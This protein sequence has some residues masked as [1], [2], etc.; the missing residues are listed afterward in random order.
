MFKKI[1]N[2]TY[3]N[4]E[5]YKLANYKYVKPISRRIPLYSFFRFPL[6]SGEFVV[7][8]PFLEYVLM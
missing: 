7:W 3:E 1:M 2:E 6:V 4:I 8:K 5:Q